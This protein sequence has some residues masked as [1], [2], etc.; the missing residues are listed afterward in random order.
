MLRSKLKQLVKPINDKLIKIRIRNKPKIF[1]IGNNKTGTTS[2][3]TAMKNLG[4]VVGEQR[5]AERMLEDW[6]QR[7]FKRIVKHCLTGEFFQDFPFSKP[8]TFVVLDHEFPSSKFILTVRDSPEQWYNSLTKFHAKKWGK[9][10]RVPTKEDLQE[11]TYLWK[12]WPWDINRANYDTPE[13][14][15]YNKEMLI[16]HYIN[17]I[18]NVIEYFRH[19]PDDLLIL[20]VAEKGAYK[21]L[22]EFLG[23]QVEQ[24]DFPWE[25]KTVDIKSK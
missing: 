7:D 14:D 12:G 21:K 11:A 18:N 15:P 10:G 16:E 24:E 3:K 4:Y 19:R 9:G 13:D 5:P 6:A 2:L 20:N 1:G 17:H 22:G 8:Y 25:N 23:K